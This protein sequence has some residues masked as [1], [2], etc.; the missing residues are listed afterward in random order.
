MARAERH[1]SQG[2]VPVPQAQL[3]NAG[4]FPAD[5][6]SAEALRTGAD[7]AGVFAE[8]AIRRREAQDSLAATQASKA[9]TQQELEMQQF[10]ANN[11][12]PD[13]W[14]K[15]FADISAKYGSVYSGLKMTPQM[16]EK[17]DIE[18]QA[19]NEQ[20]RAR[21]QLAA[22][23]QDIKNDITEAKIYL[24]SVVAN[25]DGSK[26]DAKDIEEAMESLEAALLRDT[27]SEIAANEME[28]VLKAAKKGFWVNQSKLRPDEIISEMQAKK[29]ALGKKGE[30]KDGLT[31][32]D[33]DDI[34]SSAITAKAQA[35][36]IL[37]EENREAKSDLYKRMD[38]YFADTTGEVEPPSRDDFE[39]VY[40]DPDE[41]DQHYDEFVA[42][43]R[44]ELR[45]EANR[46]KQ[47]NPISLARANAV[48]DIRPQDMT[49]DE[50]YENATTLGT[51]NVTALVDR[52]EKKQKGVYA[53]GDKY[54]SQFSTL[55][56]AGYFG[57]KG[58][59][60]TSALYLE[61]KRKMDEFIKSQKPVEA[62]AD[63]F[64]NGLITKKF[65]IKGVFRWIGGGW[66][67][68]GHTHTYIDARGSKVEGTFRFGD[69]R[70]RREGDK[71]I[72]EYYAG[73]DR[74]TKKPL[75]IPRQ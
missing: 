49:V 26:G 18:Q 40:L 6:S 15:G 60:G 8:L 1:T 25:D 14:S 17:Q 32:K 34:I 59:A 29:K 68:N 74:K 52:L 2:Q 47:G 9:R 38:E 64:F 71:V 42:G 10:M 67:E 50:I 55:F 27:T 65:G 4:N 61:Q 35:K 22:T 5:T 51:S 30:D 66:D 23:N 21:V 53:E 58:E 37:T 70:K 63:A 41:A 33:M 13:T 7:V 31:A 72:E 44:A 12:D 57:K 54:K 36:R 28:E 75:W 56:N 43:Q 24:D 48:I 46:V 20:L 45:D 11:P 19:A 3:V 39:A 62:V 69:T 73:P 16:R